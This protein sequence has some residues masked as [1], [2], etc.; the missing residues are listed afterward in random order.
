M[1]AVVPKAPLGPCSLKTVQ[2]ISVVVIIVALQKG[3][4]DLLTCLNEVPATFDINYVHPVA[5]P[6]SEKA[7]F[8]FERATFRS[9]PVGNRFSRLPPDVVA[10]M[11]FATFGGG[12]GFNPLVLLHSFPF[13]CNASDE[14]CI[15]PGVY[16]H[17]QTRDGK[18]K[19][20]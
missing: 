10:V 15:C 20:R 2:V 11:T 5:V 8:S 13:L 6:P 18:K 19:K 16:I 1:F 4:H 9:Y 17:L 7:P 12:L 14:L 3:H